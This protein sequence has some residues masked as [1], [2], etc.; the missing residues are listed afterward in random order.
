M[1]VHFFSKILDESESTRRVL[2]PGV[3]FSNHEFPVALLS[4]FQKHSLT[5][6]A[7]EDLLKLFR[8]VLPTPNTLPTSQ[9]KEFIS[10]DTNTILHQCCGSCCQLSSEKC[11]RRECQASIVKEATFVEIMIDPQRK[12]LWVRL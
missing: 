5:Y 3:Q 11:S 7:V 9:H 1:K 4:I 8:C 2:F 10:Y 12:Y 6:S